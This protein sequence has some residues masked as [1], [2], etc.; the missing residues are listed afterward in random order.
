MTPEIET[1]VRK[2]VTAM[3]SEQAMGQALLVAIPDLH[4]R[5]DRREIYAAGRALL[6]REFER[7]RPIRSRR[8]TWGVPIGA[9][10][11]CLSREECLS[12][13]LVPGL[14]ND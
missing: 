11:I 2:T 3:M 13:G 14:G 7:G 10:V 8:G 4:T 5:V 12:R 9:R 1:L 6:R